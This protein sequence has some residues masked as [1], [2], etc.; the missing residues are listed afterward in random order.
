M[1]HEGS[2]LDEA[3]TTP[4][5]EEEEELLEE[6]DPLSQDE[7]NLI[8]RG[9]LTSQVYIGGREI[10]LRTLR[11]GEELEA[12]MLVDRYK[13]SVEAA[14]ALA[15]AIVAAAITSVDGKPLVQS[16]GPTENTLE[17]RLNYLLKNWYW[18]TVRE[19]YAEY[20]RLMRRVVDAYESVKKD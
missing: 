13:D 15:T 7:S 4:M 19:V 2:L 16:L 11:I 14:R 17:T 20:N 1:E 10:K 8:Y 6:E 9:H 18:I 5:S 12:A 3:F